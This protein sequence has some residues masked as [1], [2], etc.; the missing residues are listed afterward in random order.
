MA[1]RFANVADTVDQQARR[2]FA[3]EPSDTV[4]LTERPKAIFCKTDGTIVLRDEAGTDVGYPMTAGQV[5][6]FR[7]VRVLATGTSG[8][9]VAWF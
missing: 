6:P 5:L 8:T 1:D 2:H 7:P 3:I 9:Y 4:N